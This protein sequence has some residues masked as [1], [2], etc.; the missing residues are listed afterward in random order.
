M[1]MTSP[2]S[3]FSRLDPRLQRWVY[4][5]G[6]ETL[7]PFQE[8]AILSIL[9]GQDDLILAASTATGKTEAVFLPL[10]SAVA[11]QP[12]G[13]RI[14]YLSPLKALINDQADRLERLGERVD[15]PLHR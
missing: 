9:D 15:I 3:P 4:E 5:Q 6:W 11:Q 2:V 12:G 1:T 8:E 10:L 13:L 7:R 14:L